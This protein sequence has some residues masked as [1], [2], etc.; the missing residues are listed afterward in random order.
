MHLQQLLCILGI[1]SQ[2]SF[3][4]ETSLY[5]V[6]KRALNDI[7]QNLHSRERM[8]VLCAP[9]HSI[10]K[11]VS[12]LSM[13]KG[14]FSAADA[15]VIPFRNLTDTEKVQIGTLINMD[16]L[17]TDGPGS[18]SRE[19]CER[20]CYGIQICN[21]GNDFPDISRAMELKRKREAN[22]NRLKLEGY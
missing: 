18:V 7:I 9:S 21:C 22:L 1:Q 10:S 19:F 3:L 4:A 13:L 16:T 2:H 14:Y 15:T 5:K 20:A 8:G 6:K 17:F 11:V 12:R